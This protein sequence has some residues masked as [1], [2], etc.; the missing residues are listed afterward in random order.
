MVVLKSK[1]MFRI[2]KEDEDVVG[3]VPVE[4]QVS[5]IE[6]SEVLDNTELVTAEN[7]VNQDLEKLDAVVDTGQEIVDLK[8]KNEEKL[9]TSPQEITQADV[10]ATEKDMSYLIGK[11]HGLGMNI[12]P[13]KFVNVGLEAAN[14]APIQA[15][16]IQQEGIGQTIKDFFVKIWEWIKKVFTNI[17]NFFKK[18]FGNSEKKEEKITE[19]VKASGGDSKTVANNVADKI[20]VIENTPNASADEV[21]KKFQALKSQA[22]AA[23]VKITEAKVEQMKGTIKQLEQN[24]TLLILAVAYNGRPDFVD[25]HKSYE[26]IMNI[27][28]YSMESLKSTEEIP[29]PKIISKFYNNLAKKANIDPIEDLI[30]DL[31]LSNGKLLVKYR[32]N[33]SSETSEQKTAEI[34]YSNVDL[35]ISGFARMELDNI[36]EGAKKRE[37]T[38]ELARLQNLLESMEK[39]IKDKTKECQAQIEQKSEE[40]KARTYEILNNGVKLIQLNIMAISLGQRLLV[41]LLTVTDKLL[42][43]FKV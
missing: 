30:Y 6:G 13:N 8:E 12:Q 17:K 36:L 4:Q 3:S 16:E 10:I 22:A 15:F 19:T 34:D 21:S 25:F 38:K 2:S 29:K 26:D 27:Y 24:K 35:K 41:D 18:L 37:I 9:Q 11:L 23:K 43:T 31:Q 14:A 32:S 42:D 7:E 28:L 40:E 20:E 1:N 33:A 5:N 39:D